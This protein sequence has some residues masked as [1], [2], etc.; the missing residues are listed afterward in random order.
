MGLCD[1]CLYRASTWS[2]ELNK[3]G[4]VGCKISLVPYINLDDMIKEQQDWFDYID[5]DQIGF[6][7]IK[8]GGMCYNDQPIL[9]D[10]KKCKFYEGK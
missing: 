8:V 7:W 10:V 6:G 2:E 5:V 9:K 3:Q 1:N 4:Y